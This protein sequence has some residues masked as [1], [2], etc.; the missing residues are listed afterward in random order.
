MTFDPELM[1][2]LSSV[3]VITFAFEDGKCTD[4]C[5]SSSRGSLEAATYVYC[6]LNCVNCLEGQGRPL[7]L[8][9]AGHYIE[10]GHM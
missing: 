2:M 1:R 8:G 7:P 4:Q 10:M 3:M 5:C 6:N 9:V